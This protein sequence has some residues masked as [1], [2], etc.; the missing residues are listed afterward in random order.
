MTV[1]RHLASQHFRAELANYATDGVCNICLRQPPSTYALLMHVG[2]VHDV[3]EL[4]LRFLLLQSGGDWP[5][6]F[7]LI[8]RQ[9]A[10]RDA[11][12]QHQQRPGGSPVG[13]PLGR[14]DT[15]AAAAEEGEDGVV[16]ARAEA[17][18]AASS[19]DTASVISAV[20]KSEAAEV[21]GWKEE[22]ELA[23]VKGEPAEVSDD[24]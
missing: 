11:L 17:V 2:L 20:M 23:A 4:K 13:S 1:V 19:A 7:A 16:E 10:L 8:G 21:D 18:A 6:A 22:E 14:E 24:D 3:V 15:V 9:A 12:R 5:A